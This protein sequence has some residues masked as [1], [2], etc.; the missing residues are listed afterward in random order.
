MICCSLNSTQGRRGKIEEWLQNVFQPEKTSLC[1]TV[2]VTLWFLQLLHRIP[3]IPFCR[4]THVLHW[5]YHTSVGREAKLLENEVTPRECWLYICSPFSHVW[6]RVV[7]FHGCFAAKSLSSCCRGQGGNG[8]IQNSVTC[9]NRYFP[10]RLAWNKL[11]RQFVAFSP[12]RSCTRRLRP[13]WVEHVGVVHVYER[14]YMDKFK[15]KQAELKR[16]ISLNSGWKCT[17]STTRL[18]IAFNQRLHK[19]R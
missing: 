5:P 4:W 8:P 13:V 19:S 12:G 9:E 11:P 15:R 2:Q 16:W 14:N 3:I 7:N 17:Q 10:G 6:Q 1:F 18:L